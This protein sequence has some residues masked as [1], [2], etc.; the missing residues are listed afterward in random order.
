MIQESNKNLSVDDYI[1]I[2][3][4]LTETNDEHNI[5]II[6]GEPT[7]HPNFKDILIESNYYGITNDVNFTLFTNGIEL[8]QYLSCIG[9]KIRILINCNN[10]I[11]TN[12]MESFY[13]T[14]T[15]CFDLGWLNSDKARLGCN[16]HLQEKQYEWIW[17]LVDTFDIHFLRCSVV[18]PGGEYLNWRNK[19]D[20]YFKQMKPIFLEFCKEAKKRNVKLGLDCGYIPSCYFS[21]KELDFIKSIISNHSY[22]IET[23]C[24][25]VMDITPDLN[26][27]PCFG[28]YNHS[29]PLDFNKNWFGLFRYFSYKYNFPKALNNT[30]GSCA[31]C[32]KLCDFQCQGGCLAFSSPS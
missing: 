20:E 12:Q 16:L 21:N 32:D 18:S 29:I 13:S 23:G 15:H 25:P 3:K 19:K 5:G 2:L 1:K 24:Q 28:L 9:D 8:E 30:Q 10:I 27:V 6:G 4:Y 11:N 14:I 26:V 17:S 31:N 22:N 7:L